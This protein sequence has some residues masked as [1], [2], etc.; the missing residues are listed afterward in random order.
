MGGLYKLVASLHGG[1]ST[2]WSCHYQSFACVVLS[3][4]KLLVYTW[5][6]PHCIYRLILAT[7]FSIFNFVFI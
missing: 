3:V 1:W 2:K 7:W 4:I 6:Y 5:S